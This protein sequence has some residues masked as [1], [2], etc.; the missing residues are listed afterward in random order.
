MSKDVK[1]A[2]WKYSCLINVE[3]EDLPPLVYQYEEKILRVTEF[4]YR[5][6]ETWQWRGGKQGK[7]N[8]NGNEMPIVELAN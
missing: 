1:Q 4:R 8:S 5:I 7:R 2:L 3:M 6:A